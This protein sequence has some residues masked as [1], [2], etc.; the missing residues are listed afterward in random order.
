L[1]RFLAALFF[2]VLVACTSTNQFSD[3][4][5]IISE[6]EWSNEQ[7]L[8]ILS[9]RLFVY[10]LEIKDKSI[11]EV[12]L[13]IEY[14]KDGEPEG[15][16]QWFS[17][18]VNEQDQA[19]D[20]TIAYVQQTFNETDERWVLA[21]MDENGFGSSKLE[22]NWPKDRE[23]ELGAIWGDVSLPLDLTKGEKTV[24]GF[25]VYSSSSV[26]S[27]PARIETEEDL[28]KLVDAEYAYVLS[29]EVN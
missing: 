27:S 18:P 8:N 7:I 3:A 2:I 11:N 12:S 24:V 17:T 20:L 1:P 6:T 14:Y 13:T 23:E 15:D 28:Q 19:N 16:A 10:D 25:L 9:D 4:D 22:N 29:I 5:A 26:I 21:I